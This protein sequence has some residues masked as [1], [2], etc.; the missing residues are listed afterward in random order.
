MSGIQPVKLSEN[1]SYSKITSTGYTALAGLGV[2]T[3]LTF[4]KNKSVKKFHKPFGLITVALSL[5]HLGA[6][7]HTKA[8]WKK[9]AA[10]VVPDS[11]AAQESEGA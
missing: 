1:K 9:K 6:I 11:A 3:A 7:M 8:E 4:A 10:E 5:M 2:T